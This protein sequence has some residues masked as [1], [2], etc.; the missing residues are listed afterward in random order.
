MTAV[1]ADT[2][3]W[4]ALADSTDSAHQLALNLTAARATSRIFTTDEVLT[5][6]LT[7]FQP[8][9]NSFAARRLKVSK[10]CWP[11]PSFG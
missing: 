9:R 4:I 6:Y 3:Y 11:V 7:F 10:G 2:F 1:F 5:E 8:H